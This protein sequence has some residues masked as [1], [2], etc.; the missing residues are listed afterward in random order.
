MKDA[1]NEDRET[2]ERLIL[3]DLRAKL[4]RKIDQIRGRR[5]REMNRRCC[6]IKYSVVVGIGEMCAKEKNRWWKSLQN[7]GCREEPWILI[8][9]E[10]KKMACSAGSKKMPRWRIR[11]EILIWRC[12]D[13]V[14]IIAK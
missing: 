7:E 4:R 3:L 10:V 12:G 2:V 6:E 5:G 9:I 1:Q 14:E 13:L 8:E 11:W